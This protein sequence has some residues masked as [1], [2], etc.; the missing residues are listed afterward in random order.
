MATTRS[1]LA[2]IG[3]GLLVVLD[4]GLVYMAVDHVRGDDAAGAA[5]GSPLPTTEPT[6]E[7]TA[8]PTDEPTVGPTTE[9][10]EEPTD[11][12]T[13]DPT[14]GAGAPTDEETG[15]TTTEPGTSTGGV[16]LD[17]A[18]DGTLL[19]ANRG[20]CGGDLGT[21]EVS[22]NGGASF[23]V[24]DIGGLT[25]VL[26]L[27]ATRAG[28]MVVVGTDPVCEPAVY[29]STDGGKTW[30]S[31]PGTGDEWHLAP[32]SSTQVHGPGGS[33]TPGCD[34]AALSP[35]N[36]A[37]AR[38]LCTDGTVLGTSDGGQGWDALGM[39]EGAVALDFTDAA[40]AWAVAET[41]ECATAIYQTVDAG[42][43]WDQRGCL[44]DGAAAA[45]TATAA[46]VTV[47]AGDTLMTST[48]EGETWETP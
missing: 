13:G 8:D 1:S 35:V 4:I 23:T 42:I 31:A 44:D 7:P 25:S 43:D 47:Q 22:T 20:G 2:A 32:A 16:L 21:V 46:Q 37:T 48:D 27:T 36:G 17:S 14:A 40:T 10:T 30:Q 12:E 26:G 45:V 5:V 33:A 19:R 15:A 9:P 18:A 6:P 38:V 34:V 3:L 29:S 11:E 28:T 41:D 24:A 39:L